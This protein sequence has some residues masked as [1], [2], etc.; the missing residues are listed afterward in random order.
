MSNSPKI[1]CIKIHIYLAIVFFVCVSVSVCL[2]VS[3]CMCV[4]LPR[5]PEAGLTTHG[6]QDTSELVSTT[7]PP[8][9]A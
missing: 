7:C 9:Y 6:H 2:S 5:F 8:L 4:S 3:V 1:V